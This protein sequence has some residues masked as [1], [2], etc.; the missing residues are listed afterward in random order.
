MKDRLAQ[1]TIV[2]FGAVA[3]FAGTEYMFTERLNTGAT[4][5]MADDTARYGL[6]LLGALGAGCFAAFL[7]ETAREEA[8]EAYKKA[9]EKK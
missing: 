6:D 9:Q 1:A 8:V 4:E 2:V 5:S 7:S 3:G